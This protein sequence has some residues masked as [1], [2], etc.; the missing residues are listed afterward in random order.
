MQTTFSLDTVPKAEIDYFWHEVNDHPEYFKPRH[1][2]RAYKSCGAKVMPDP[3][4]IG[5]LKPVIRA[6]KRKEPFSAVRIGDGEAGVIAYGAYPRTPNLDRHVMAQC[7]RLGTDSFSVTEVWMSILRDMMMASVLEADLIGCR[8]LSEVLPPFG[9]LT[10]FK[11]RARDDLRGAVGVFRAVDFMLRLA[12]RKVFRKKSVG[13]AHFYFSVLNHLETLLMHAKDVVCISSEAQV[14][15]KLNE[16]YSRNRFAHIAVGRAHPDGYNRAEPSFLTEVE[17]CL[18][19]DLQ[20]TL[21][22]V[23]AGIWSEIYCT[24]IRR[25]G[26]VAVDIGSGF[27]LLAGKIS[28]P[29]HRRVL[30]DAGKAYL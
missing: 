3:F 7:L 28:R 16:K 23:G 13:S 15:E 2:M 19:M 18:P 9:D 24:Y 14:T 26:G 17:R 11:E 10:D 29:V 8:N 27:D 1:V 4:G 22:L 20:G 12:R 6:L 21:C 25:R 30:G 5:V